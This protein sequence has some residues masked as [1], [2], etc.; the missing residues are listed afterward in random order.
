[1]MADKDPFAKSKHIK[2]RFLNNE[3]PE[4][5][6]LHFAYQ[7]KYFWLR[8]GQEYSLPVEV[9]EHLNSLSIPQYKWEHDPET[10]GTRSVETGQLNRFTCLPVDFEN[11]PDSRVQQQK[12][13]AVNA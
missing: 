6:E 12:K 5:G 10:G 13:E 4:G 11:V 7:G 1:M 8:N 9:V 3:D 2:V